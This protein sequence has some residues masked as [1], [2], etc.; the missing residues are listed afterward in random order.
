MSCSVVLDRFYREFL[1]WLSKVDYGVQQADLIAKCQEGTG[2]WFLESTEFAAWIQGRTA[3]LLCPGIPG[4]GKTFMSS[5][6]VNHLGERFPRR[7][8]V[9]IAVLYCSY[10]MRGEQ[11]KEKLLAGL[12]RQLLQRKHCCSETVQSLYEQCKSA[13]RRPSLDEMVVLLKHVA[14]SFSQAFVVVDAL[15]ECEGTEW[16]PLVRELRRLQTLFPA[17]RLMFTFRPHVIVLE[18]MA[19]AAT[20]NIRAHRSDIEH[21]VATHL[22]RLSQHVTEAANLRRDVIQGIVAAADGM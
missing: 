1:N 22:S 21:Y 18:E 20:L 5:I 9:G 2:E 8:G 3:T 12:L 10:S 14:S 15:D 16:S 11:A 6:V 13:G 7:D 4:A 19:E 17:L